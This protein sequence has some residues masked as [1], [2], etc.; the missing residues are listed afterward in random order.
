MSVWVVG[1]DETETTEFFYAGFAAPLE[2]WEDWFIPAWQER[3]LNGPPTIPLLHMTD[4]RSEKWRDKY[5]LSRPESERR[6]DEAFRV[7]RSLGSL[8]PILCWTN[9]EH[10]RASL[11]E[12]KIVGPPRAQFTN[13]Y[14]YEPDYLCF[15]NL[16]MIAIFY[17]KSVDPAPVK[18]DFIVER[19]GK[20]TEHMKDFHESM[21]RSFRALGHPEHA[22]LIGDLIPAGKDCLPLQAADLLCWYSQREKATTLSAREGQRYYDI[23]HRPRLKYEL[24]RERIT[25][26]PKGAEENGFPS[27]DAARASYETDDED[28]PL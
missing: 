7:I 14:A 6:V 2:D 9:A 10:F 3:V 19:N 16:A 1:A 18:V 12:R 21:V 25:E 28:V 15:I 13:A 8:Y 4:I 11:G 26:L 27:I 17:V 24:T 20:I 22:D 5:G 23:A